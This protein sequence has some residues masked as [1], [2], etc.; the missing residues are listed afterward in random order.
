MTVQRSL[1]KFYV[2]NPYVS[3]FLI[4][5]Y[6]L[7]S[8]SFCSNRSQSF[9]F[10]L[11]FLH[12]CNF[13]FFPP[14]FPEVQGSFSDPLQTLPN[15]IK[16]CWSIE[17]RRDREREKEREPVKRNASN[18]LTFTDLTFSTHLFFFPPFILFSNIYILIITL[19]QA[20]LIVY[21]AWP[22]Q[23]QQ[24]P[25]LVSSCPLLSS[26][27]TLLMILQPP[28]ATSLSFCISLHPT[29]YPSSPFQSPYTPHT[30]QSASPSPTCTQS[31]AIASTMSVSLS[32][33]HLAS[34]AL[35]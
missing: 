3:Y 1:S 9:S 20:L 7:T 19:H 29:C 35:A 30:L 6:I 11:F 16:S 33:P 24:L 12:I 8:F 25:V 2:R 34:L 23:S 26:S 5:Y 10:F 4:L 21:L 31:T 22:L 17:F 18:R 27:I 32:L 14:E 13:F 15:Y 28:I